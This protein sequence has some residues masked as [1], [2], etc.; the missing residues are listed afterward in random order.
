LKRYSILTTMAAALFA[1]CALVVPA[2]PARADWWM[3]GPPRWW[4]KYVYPGGH[5]PHWAEIVRFNVEGPMV[6]PSG[7]PGYEVTFAMQNQSDTDYRGGDSWQIKGFCDPSPQPW[8]PV[9]LGEGRFPAIGRG[10]IHLMRIFIA[11]RRRAC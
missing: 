1:F 8:R 11:H 5:P 2:L 7:A 3:E 10:N 6:L 4:W 9:V